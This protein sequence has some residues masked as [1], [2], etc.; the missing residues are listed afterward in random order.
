MVMGSGRGGGGEG[1]EFNEYLCPTIH[2][3]SEIQSPIDD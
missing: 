3:Q 2:R 1:D